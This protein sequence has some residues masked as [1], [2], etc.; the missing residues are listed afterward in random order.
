[1]ARVLRCLWALALTLLLG[2]VSPT[3]PLPPPETPLISAGSTPNRYLLSGGP[4]GAQPN[5]FVI[6]INSNSAVPRN[7]RVNGT[8]ADEKGAWSV[9][10][11]ASPGQR[12][13]IT[14][15]IGNSR[16]PPLSILIPR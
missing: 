12:I 14:Q 2:C 3:L 1:M 5:A 8:Q 6:A 13:D 7:L 11:Y 4:G 9:E 15:E 10:V 16:S